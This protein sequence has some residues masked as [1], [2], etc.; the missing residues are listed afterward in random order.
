MI[1][2]S[3]SHNKYVRDVSFL[4]P[5]LQ[6]TSFFQVRIKRKR[7]YSNLGMIFGNE[8]LSVA[9]DLLPPTK[10]GLDSFQ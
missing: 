6:L 8:F 4:S 10:T 3:V 9:L 2:I 1:F 5:F 7:F